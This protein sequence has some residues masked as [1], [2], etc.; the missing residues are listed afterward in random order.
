MSRANQK[1]Q[2][3][4]CGEA[5]SSLRYSTTC[6]HCHTSA[7]SSCCRPSPLNPKFVI[8]I[9]CIRAQKKKGDVDDDRPKWL[10]EA[11]DLRKTQAP[12]S[13]PSN[14][15]PHP[16]QNHVS[17]NKPVDA[18]DDRP[19]WLQ[20]AQ[21]T[22]DR[23][24][25]VL[26][27]NTSSP[28]TSGQPSAP[29]STDALEARMKKLKEDVAIIRPTN[30]EDELVARMARLRDQHPADYAACR[31]PDHSILR[32]LP[33]RTEADEIESLITQMKERATLDGGDED[34]IE[35]LER[36]LNRLKK[37]T[38][39]LGIS[40]S[41]IKPNE[42]RIKKKVIGNESPMEVDSDEEAER[43]VKMLTAKLPD[44][45]EIVDDSDEWFCVICPED[46]VL[47]CIDC[48]NDKYCMRCFR[49]CHRDWAA[50]DHRTKQ[51]PKRR[52]QF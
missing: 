27:E 1:D 48:D 39:A 20:E 16:S 22:S 17:T 3:R 44:M 30:T 50:E 24:Q 2:C 18:F 12:S 7:C 6:S 28:A 47:K 10:R 35:E 19:K 32:P 46:P 37:E 9:S 51:L 49:E 52:S 41:A 31:Q 23:K 29:S 40:N 8:C 26:A 25:T 14:P 4:L 34:V 21:K 43:V 36:R 15:P 5:Y 11:Q 42:D 38:A 13:Q 45:D 33:V